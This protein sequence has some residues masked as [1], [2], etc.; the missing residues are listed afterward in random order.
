MRLGCVQAKQFGS[1]IE[2]AASV[3]DTRLWYRV[4]AAFG[5]QV[6]AEPFLVAGILPAMARGEA[7]EVS[8]AI[9]ISPR[10]SASLPKVQQI[11]HAWIPALQKIDVKATCSS[12]AQ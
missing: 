9:G 2:I 12:P 6:R 7:L 5:D 3:G 1:E 8:S 4:P 10:L 11:L